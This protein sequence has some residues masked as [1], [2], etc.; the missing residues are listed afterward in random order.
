[1][2]NEVNI[3]EK[4]RVYDIV[5]EYHSDLMCSN[6]DAEIHASQESDGRVSIRPNNSSDYVC[7]NSFTFTHSDPDRVI[8]VAKMIL[9]FAE[10]VKNENKKSI[11]I[12]DK[13]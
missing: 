6:Y 5:Y 11:D 12:S 3:E 4:S 2:N 9:A 7:C 13:L 10:M 1:M 8:A